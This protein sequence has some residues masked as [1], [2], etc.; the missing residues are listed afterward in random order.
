MP[1]SKHPEPFWRASRNSYC[2][3]IGKKQHRLS[4]DRAYA[5]RL[6]PELMSRLPERLRQLAVRVPPLVV[7]V[8]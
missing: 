4:P 6:Y 7:E 1:G 2:L 8:I 3:R 5:S